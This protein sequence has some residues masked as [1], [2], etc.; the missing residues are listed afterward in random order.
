[1]LPGRIFVAGYFVTRP[2][3]L[4]GPAPALFRIAVEARRTLPISIRFHGR[5]KPEAELSWIL[6]IAG[7]FAPAAR[8]PRQ[9]GWLAFP[10]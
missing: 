10:L 7:H 9:M 1:M 4:K 8:V 5:P 6:A 2:T 3:K